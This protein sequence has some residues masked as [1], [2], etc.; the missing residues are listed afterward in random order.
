MLSKASIKRPVTTIMIMIIVIMTGIIALTSLKLDLMPTIDIPIAAVMTTYVG[1]SPEDIEN[2]VTE[3]IEEALGTVA[4]VDTITSTSSANSSIVIIQFVDGT[5]LDMAAIDIREQ[6]DL[7]KGS[8]PDDANEPIVFKMDVSALSSST[9]VGVT[10]DAMGLVELNTLLEDNIVSRFERIEGVASADLSGGIENEIEIVVEPDK[11]EGYGITTSQIS[12]ILKAENSNYPSGNI[13]QGNNKLQIRSLG[14]FQSIEEIKKLPITTGTGGIIH[15]DDIATVKEAQKDRDS[16]SYINGKPSIMINIQKQSTANTVDISDK[17]VAEIDKIQKEYPTLHITMLTNTADYIKTSINNVVQT[18][19]QAAILAVIILVLFLKDGRTSLII[20]ISIPTSILAT[21]ALMYVADMTMNMISMG[22]ITIGIGMLVDNSV[23]VLE[24]IFKKWQNGLRAK[25]ASEEGATEVAMAVM[26][27]TLTTVAVFI[28]L[29]FVSGTV[30]QM[31]RDLSLTITFSLVASLVVSLTFVPMACSK[32]LASEENRGERRVTLFTRFLDAW[33]RGLEAIDRG[34]RVVLAFCLKNKKKTVLLVIIAFIATLSL[35]PIIGID[36]MPSMDEGSASVSISLPKGSAVEETQKITNEVVS[37]ID[38]IPETED[39]YVTVGSSGMMMGGSSDSATVQ[40]NF[41]GKDE[42]QRSTEEIVEDIRQRI[43]GI[44]GAD[45][46]VSAS[47]SAMGSMGGASINMQ[48]SGDDLDQLRIIGDD[49]INIISQIDGTRDVTSSSEDTVPE[50]NI[51]INHAK[52]SNYGITTGTI[53]GVVNTAVSGSVATTYKVNGTEL[54]V[55][56]RQNKDETKYINDI[57]NLS[58]NSPTGAIVQLSDVAD[59]QLKDSA[60]SVSRENQ[61]R[62]ITVEAA[63]VNRDMNSVKEE[64]DNRL[65]DYVFPDGYSYKYTGILETMGESYSNLVLVLI[66]AIA[67]VYMIMASQ[68]ESL[69]HPF[70]VMF[71]IP[72]AITGGIFGLFITGNTISVTAMMGFIMLVGMVVNNAIVLIDYTNQLLERDENLTCNEALL[73]AGPN[74]LRPILMTT[75]TTI[76]GL[77]PMAIATTEGT[78]MQRPLAISV[79]FGLSISTV[80]T[81]I[82]IPVLYSIIDVIR[83]RSIKKKLKKNKA[84]KTSKLKANID[85]IKK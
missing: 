46:T 63:V 26:A 70:I 49:M 71:S 45:I 15:I 62:Y 28:P 11:M 29:M 73:E 36:F 77:I 4:N 79:I 21:F 24:N 18:A 40:L 39:M 17:V 22:G 38:D 23:V 74:R 43:K 60:Q 20:G 7:V 61:H 51:K 56:I 82:F 54:D 9:I 57:K 41:I 1:A 16:Y 37:R 48:I 72:L 67:L 81:L 13:W 14:E 50:V 19:F 59:V 35:V 75:L 84:N 10:S 68:F 2:L 76:I 55:R 85:L 30:G 6:V 27:S 42:R 65:T 5:D 52:A 83:F 12:Q 69:I 66:V 58:I 80:V 3:P 25:E 78:E 31:F 44:A 34:Y 8:L 47:S 64:I 53:A 33:G 32:V